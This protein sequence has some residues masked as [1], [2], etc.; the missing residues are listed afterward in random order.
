MVR[1]GP[2]REII[3][4]LA[5]V[6]WFDGSRSSLGR[7]LG[8]TCRGWHTVSILTLSSSM[9][10]ISRRVR[11]TSP[12]GALRL[13][14]WLAPPLVRAKDATCGLFSKFRSAAPRKKK[15]WL[16]LWGCPATS[17]AAMD[18]RSK[19]RTTEPVVDKVR[20]GEISVV[21]ALAE[22][23]P[24]LFEA[25]ILPKLDMWATLNL[26]QV[27]KSF[28]RAVWSVGGVRSM[29]AKIVAEAKIHPVPQ[30]HPVPLRSNS[31]TE[32]DEED[33]MWDTAPMFWAAESGNLPAVRALLESGLDVNKGALTRPLL[34]AVTKGREEVVKAL[35]EAGADV[36]LTSSDN[37]SNLRCTLPLVAAAFS[38]RSVC[39]AL[40]LDAGADVD[41]QEDDGCT[42]LYAAAINGQD[43]VV[44]I[45]I[46]AGADINRAVFERTPLQWAALALP[47][48]PD[49]KVSTFR[50]LID[51]GADVHRA[52]GNESTAL[53]FAALRGHGV[54]VGILI[55]AGADVNR[56]NNAGRT[57]MSMA[58]KK[59][60]EY[61][62][63]LL[64]QAGAI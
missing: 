31:D 40:L 60:D 34:F 10:T 63:E 41:K 14:L 1:S 53:H 44:K 54:K 28:N 49:G 2:R 24:D 8:R 37:L 12:A 33:I 35:I 62:I 43:A 18:T 3:G 57:P 42:A 6:G 56:V 52:V 45:L 32:D 22:E 58:L 17:N 13:R 5:S 39:I 36:N 4:H 16:A 20:R 21:V 64:K 46:D 15:S 26:A 38:G 30:I 11:P 48:E 59:G 61:T 47:G 27:S 29:E 23:L 9:T 55:K 25:E 7:G 50:I 19:R 51:A